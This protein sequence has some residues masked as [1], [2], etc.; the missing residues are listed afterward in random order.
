MNRVS[1][2]RCFV[3]LSVA[4]GTCMGVV[5]VWAMGGSAGAAPNRDAPEPIRATAFVLVDARGKS[6]GTWSIVDD[7]AVLSMYDADGITRIAASV[8]TDSVLRLYDAK[9]QELI[10]ANATQRNGSTLR[11]INEAG[12]TSWYL[13]A[14]KTQAFLGAALG[15]KQP[16]L[17]IT[18]SDDGVAAVGINNKEGK[19]I[20]QAP[21]EDKA[22]K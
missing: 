5:A 19:L 7:S 20:W 8:G 6:R 18:A 21:S 22:P 15:S 4:L 10:K 12:Q 14:S 2:T 13:V 16:L 11:M 17:F 1:C 3:G 9:G